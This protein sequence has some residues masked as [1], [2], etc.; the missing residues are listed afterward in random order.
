MDAETE[1]VCDA[2][3]RDGIG[4]SNGQKSGIDKSAMT[5][6]IRKAANP[7]VSLSRI[8]FQND[9]TN[10]RSNRLAA[11]QKLATAGFEAVDIEATRVYNVDDAR[12][13]LKAAGIDADSIALKVQDKF[14]SAFVRAQKPAT[15]KACCGPTCCAAN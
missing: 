15:A 7:R 14:N 2:C 6:R 10:H 12:G 11:R 5:Q 4:L 9:S 13:F 3:A 8:I 1:S